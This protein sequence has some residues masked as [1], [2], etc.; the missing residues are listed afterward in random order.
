MMKRFK[1]LFPLGISMWDQLAIIAVLLWIVSIWSTLVFQ[2]NYWDDVLR[3]CYVDF[4]D[5]Y[6]LAVEYQMPEFFP[7]IRNCFDVTIWYIVAM[8][9]MSAYNYLY[10][11]GSYKSIYLMRRLP[12]SWEFHR[13]CLCIPFLGVVSVGVLIILMIIGFYGYYCL[14]QLPFEYEVIDWF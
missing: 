3:K 2:E 10:H 12:N 1:R 9:G 14:F 4:E 5:Y 7:M 8:L 13:R 11:Y 6:H